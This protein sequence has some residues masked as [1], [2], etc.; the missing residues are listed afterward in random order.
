LQAKLRG[1]F[2]AD[3]ARDGGW[4]VPGQELEVAWNGWGGV[5]AGDSQ[6]QFCSAAEIVLMRSGDEAGIAQR[7]PGV[8]RQGHDDNLAEIEIGDYESGQAEY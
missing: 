7:G 1:R 3:R 2:G 8:L 6:C 4:F 5:L